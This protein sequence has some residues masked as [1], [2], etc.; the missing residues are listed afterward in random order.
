MATE[1]IEGFLLAL[2]WM[3]GGHVVGVSFILVSDNL[4]ST[5][6]KVNVEE[7]KVLNSWDV[8]DLGKIEVNFHASDFKYG[9]NQ[10]N[11][12]TRS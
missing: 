10:S 8:I 7:D 3:F 5:L 9:K 2:F 12:L 11:I 1:D 6:V 4:L